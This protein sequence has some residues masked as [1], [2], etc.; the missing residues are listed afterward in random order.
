MVLDSIAGLNKIHM[1]LSEFLRSEQRLIRLPADV[2]GSPPLIMNSFQFWRSRRR[3]VPFTF[4]FLLSERYEL[5]A[6]S[7]ISGYTLNSFGFATT[8]M[9]LTIILNMW[10]C[11]AI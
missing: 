1:R 9:V 3:R 7:I 8:R 6:S 2:S 4:Q 5:Q 10:S 11:L